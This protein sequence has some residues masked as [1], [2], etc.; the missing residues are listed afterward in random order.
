M[1]VLFVN[2]ICGIG[3]TGAIVT[4]LLACL[5]EHGEG[6]KIAFGFGEAKRISSPDDCIKMN[7]KFGYYTHN[8]LSR[9]TDHAGLYSTRETRSFVEKIKAYNPDIIHLHNL[10][11]YYLN[12]EV[13]FRFLRSYQ[14][15]VVWTLH[16]CWAF[17]G[18][19]PHFVRTNCMQWKTKC[20]DCAELR[21]YPKCYFGGD[22]GYNFEKKKESFTSLSDLTL[23]TPSAWLMEL[24]KQS[25]LGKYPVQV[26]P[27]G[28][29]TEI[30][31]PHESDFREKY[32]LQGQKIVLGVA[33]VWSEKKGLGDFIKLRSMLPEDFSVVLVG[34]SEKQLQTLPKNIIGIKRTENA[35][36]L[37]E[38]YS[39]ADVFFNPTYEDTYPT[40][41]MEAQACAT[42]VVVYDVGGCAETLRGEN[43]RAIPRG[44]LNAAKEAVFSLIGKR[45]VPSKSFCKKTAAENYMRLYEQVLHHSQTK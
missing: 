17:T 13:L 18:H 9:L 12:Y 40:V 35:R 4:D 5:K 42:P 34:L 19:C 15:P 45:A 36:A 24:V 30:F 11:G 16:D 20:T 10:H 29:D 39:A 6:G 1:K 21:H 25:F 8:F 28:I 26:I 31:A 33:N 3:S 2:A 43:G 27:N 37:A 44:D 7:H 32:N 38:I 41:N 14:K 23:V 22:V